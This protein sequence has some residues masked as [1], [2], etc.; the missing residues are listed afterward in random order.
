MQKALAIFEAED[1]KGALEPV[2]KE[3]EELKLRHTE[4]MSFFQDLENK[5]DDNAIIIKFEPVN[6]RDD[7]E[8]AFKMFSKALD[9]VPPNK[10]ADPSVQD[11]NYLSKKRYLIRNAY[12]GVGISLRVEGKKVQRLI[13]KHIRSLDIEQLIPERDITYENFLGFAAKFKNERA[14]TALIKNK[15][16]QIIR[17]HAPYNPAYFEKLRE[18]LE[19]I[20]QEEEKRRK[21]DASY[22]NNYKKIYEEAL[23]EERKRKE[24]GFSTPFEFAIYEELKSLKNNDSI[25]KNISRAIF[26]KIKEETGIVGWKT[27]KS[28]EKRMSII[29]YDILNEHK[30]RDDKVNEL[31]QQF[32]ELAKR[33]L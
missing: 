9:A 24:L 29:I 18:R 16:R 6:V 19:K 23:N 12:E 25:S 27:K 11:F 3:V 8:Y 4:A 7:F 14:R 2:E 30:F 13:D 21:G 5:E 31:T 33:D 32:M 22:F 20:I 15:A 26:D 1:I 10:E 28:S 17:E